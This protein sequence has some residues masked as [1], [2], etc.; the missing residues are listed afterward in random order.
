MPFDK[1]AKKLIDKQVT[2]SPPPALAEKAI[3]ALSRL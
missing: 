1:L 3:A 2:P